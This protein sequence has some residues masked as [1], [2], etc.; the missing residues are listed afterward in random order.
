[1][2]VARPWH[3]AGFFL[4][5][6]LAKRT[7]RTRIRAWLA[8]QTA[9]PQVLRQCETCSEKSW[10]PLDPSIQR[11]VLDA[12]LPNGTR[13]DALLLDGNDG[14]QL[15]VQLDGSRLP[16]RVDMR[17]GLP[18]I[19]LNERSIEG[20]PARW[21]AVRES[22]LPAWR[23]RCAGTRALPVDDDFSLRVIGCPIRLRSENGV[24]YARVIDDCGRCAFFVGIGYVGPDRRRIQLRCGFG[25]PPVERRPA[26]SATG[27]TPRR[28]SVVGS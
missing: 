26:I 19:V 25:A 14:I 6:S 12:K 16:N 11:V 4:V 1:M 24:H 15:V 8:G 7:L 17:A 21:I 5:M 22:N 18:M 2:S 3:R 9:A 20:E 10:Q 13:A 27:T 23:C 28:L